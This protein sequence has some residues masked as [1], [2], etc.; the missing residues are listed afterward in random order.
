MDLGAPCAHEDIA[1]GVVAKFAGLCFLV[2]ARG[3]TYFI[4]G[5]A[6]WYTPEVSAALNHRAR[7]DPA[8]ADEFKKRA[9]QM[10][11]REF[12][13]AFWEDLQTQASSTPTDQEG[14]HDP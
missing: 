11:D 1:T 5:D 3:G 2:Y 4:G 13:K 10:H 7:T 6:S 14:G 9:L 12:I 8:F